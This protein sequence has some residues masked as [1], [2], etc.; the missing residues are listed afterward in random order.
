MVDTME[1]MDR[2]SR[3]TSPQP[4]FQMVTSLA[5]LFRIALSRGRRII[6]LSD[7][8]DH[9]RHYLNIQQIR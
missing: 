4:L 1:A 3:R 9:A 6:P 2:P 5:R 7:E 8:L